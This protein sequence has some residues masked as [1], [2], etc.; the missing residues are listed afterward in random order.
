MSLDTCKPSLRLDLLTVE[1]PG[2]EGGDCT[3]QG[4]ISLSS[5]VPEVSPTSSLHL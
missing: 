5:T 2:L 3:D 1:L 4:R